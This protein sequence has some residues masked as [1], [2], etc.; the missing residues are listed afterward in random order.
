MAQRQTTAQ[1]TATQVETPAQVE[2]GLPAIWG[3]NIEEFAGHNL[4][5]KE[6]LVGTPFLIIGA[7]I[8]RTEGKTYDVAY[9]YAIDTHGTEFEFSDTSSTGVRAQIQALLA[10]KGLPAHAGAGFQPLRTAIRRGLR[11]SPFKVLDEATGKMRSV[12]TYYLS[13]SG[14]NVSQPPVNEG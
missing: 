1:K 14:R 8:E 9:I 5:D 4:T 10:E 13:A 2:T 12:T 6:D 7:E 3:D 11:P